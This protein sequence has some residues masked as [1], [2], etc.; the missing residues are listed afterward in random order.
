MSSL[1]RWPLSII[2]HNILI[3]DGSKPVKTTAVLSAV[4]RKSCLLRSLT[5]VVH[6]IIIRYA[7][8]RFALKITVLYLSRQSR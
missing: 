3:V 5:E 2:L 4:L 6:N 7:F 8:A 1:V